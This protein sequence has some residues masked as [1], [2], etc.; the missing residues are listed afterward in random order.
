[1]SC[2]GLQCSTYVVGGSRQC[3]RMSAWLV[4]TPDCMAWSC[5]PIEQ[6]SSVHA[7]PSLQEQRYI[8]DPWAHLW[9]DVHQPRQPLPAVP[10]DLTE[11][12]ALPT[13]MAGNEWEVHMLS[14]TCR[15]CL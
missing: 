14:C 11:A 9:G 6:C 4:D 15:W 7:Y 3:S 13:A 2:K 10:S 12:G 1:M 5:S 8:P